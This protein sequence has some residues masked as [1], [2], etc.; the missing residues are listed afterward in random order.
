MPSLLIVSKAQFRLSCETEIDPEGPQSF[1]F[2]VFMT[3]Q[4]AT[5]QKINGGFFRPA[6]CSPRPL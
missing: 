5:F 1:G 3:R 6:P 2:T 4:S